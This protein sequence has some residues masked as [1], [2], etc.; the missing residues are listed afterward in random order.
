MEGG[1]GYGLGAV[2]RNEVT[3]T[4]GVVD[5]QNFPDYE[6]LRITDM[7]DVEVHIVESDLAPSGVGEPGLPPAGP[8]LANAI[9]AATGKRITTLPMASNGVTFA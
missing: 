3:L 2:M 5:Q 7:P 8:A 9:Y 4:D 6:P 1:I